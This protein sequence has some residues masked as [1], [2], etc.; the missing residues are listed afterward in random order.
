MRVRDYMR[1]YWRKFRL[2][3]FSKQLFVLITVTSLVYPLIR[4]GRVD[5]EQ[6]FILFVM[7]YGSLS[8][9]LLPLYAGECV[10][11]ISQNN[12]PISRV[13]LPESDYD[14]R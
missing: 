13:Q 11:A 2:L 9:A 7:C 1:K 6:F 8:F 3:P 12:T 14:L 5:V 4:E 10:V